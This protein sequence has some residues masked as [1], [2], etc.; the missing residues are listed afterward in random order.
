MKTEGEKS[1]HFYDCSQRPRIIVTEHEREI[2]MVFWEIA[3]LL[4]CLKPKWQTLNEIAN[5]IAGSYSE[6]TKNFRKVHGQYYNHTAV[7]CLSGVGLSARYLSMSTLWIA[8]IC[9]AVSLL[10]DTEAADISSIPSLT[11]ATTIS[12]TEK[13]KSPWRSHTTNSPKYTTSRL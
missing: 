3:K 1:N 13:V 8:C 9:I 12:S 11:S 10:V 4:F 6:K 5:V 7:C 2:Q